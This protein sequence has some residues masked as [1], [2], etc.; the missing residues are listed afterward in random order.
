M[1]DQHNHFQNL[2]DQRGTIVS[3]NGKIVGL[4]DA[5]ISVFDR[6][7]LN[8]N[9]AEKLNPSVNAPFLAPIGGEGCQ[10]NCRAEGRAI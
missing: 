2:K 3:I 4:S 9:E 8:K 5:S 1:N 10:R 6:S 7:F